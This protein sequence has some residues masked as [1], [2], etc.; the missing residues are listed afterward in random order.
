MHI[1]RPHITHASSLIRGTNPK[2]DYCEFLAVR[3]LSGILE[4][5]QFWVG[6]KS[7]HVDRLCDAL[8]KLI[9]DPRMEDAG[10][11]D[12]GGVDCLAASVLSGLTKQ[13]GFPSRS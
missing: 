8:D 9:D 7:H 2:P 11:F 10:Q 12:R 13:P 5:P 4:M 1:S 6:A 3:Y